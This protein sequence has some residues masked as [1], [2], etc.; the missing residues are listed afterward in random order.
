M[1][2]LFMK[3]SI[4]QNGKV[5]IADYDDILYDTLP[6]GKIIVKNIPGKVM[7]EPIT[8][9]DAQ[10]RTNYTHSDNS[11]L[12]DG[13]IKNSRHYN[14]DITELENKPRM[15]NSPLNPVTTLD[16]DTGEIETVFD[17]KKRMTLI[18]DNTRVYKGGSWR[19]REFWL[20][21]AQRRYL[22]QYMA[23]EFIGFR[24]A[25]DKVGNMTE[26]KKKPYHQ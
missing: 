7:Y 12:G 17:D 26:S 24:C 20:D 21:P 19:D 14:V 1:L 11:S 5:I 6:S 13:D 22:P 25:L 10:L 18:G 16:Y 4:D 23:T 15:Y 2:V 9:S 8:K 3:K